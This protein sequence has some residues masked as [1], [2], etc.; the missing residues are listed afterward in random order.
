YLQEVK[1][2]LDGNSKKNIPWLFCND[3]WLEKLQR[4]DAVWD[5]NRNL[6]MEM[7]EDGTMSP[8]AIEDVK[9]YLPYLWKNPVTKNKPNGNIPWWSDD[10]GE[11]LFDGDYGKKTYCTVSNEH[12]A[13]TQDHTV[14]ASTITLC[15]VSFKSTA[16]SAKLGGKK[17][18]KG[19]SVEKIVPRSGTFYHELFHLVLGNAR[20]Y[21]IT[22]FWDKQQEF[23]QT[24][25]DYPPVDP[26]SDDE[27]EDGDVNMDE[28]EDQDLTYVQLIR[29]N[30]E[31]YLWFSVGYWYFQQTQWS[32]QTNQRWSFHNGA[33][34][35]VQI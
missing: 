28:D 24:P 11:Y 8:I 22:Y 6:V 1:N 29:E 9:N 18:T 14:S 35:L 21:D 17:P 15:P 32:K 34:E 30:P 31:T 27:D 26:D 20:T 2:F 12:L 25:D 5:S 33:G 23:L 3:K 19:L 10:L 13:A 16:A 7:A 4:T